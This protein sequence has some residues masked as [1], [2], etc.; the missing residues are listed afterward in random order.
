M[1]EFFEMFFC[2][3]VISASRFFWGK[4]KSY[5][6]TYSKNGYPCLPFSVFTF[7]IGANSLET[8]SV[9]FSNFFIL[10]VLG[11]GANSQVAPAIV[12]GVMVLVVYIISGIAFQNFSGHK[13]SDICP[14]FSSLGSKRISRGVQ[15]GTPIPLRKIFKV[16]GVNNRVLSL[17]Q[18]NK[19][20]RLVERLDNFVSTNTRFMHRS[21]LKDR[22]LPAA[23]IT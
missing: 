19:P 18:G 1:S 3:F 5:A 7:L 23:I 4:E 14:P 8:N 22:L 12:Q 20:I 6:F 13:V 9:I 17:R 10:M 11:V 16:L 2:L 21:S 15:M